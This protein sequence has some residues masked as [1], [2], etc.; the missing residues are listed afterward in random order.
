MEWILLIVG[1]FFIFVL[2]GCKKPTEE[3]VIEVQL[4]VPYEKAQGEDYCLVASSAMIFRYYGENITQKK[5]AKEI[6]N[7]VA[8]TFKLLGYARELGFNAE[9]KRI[10]IR[11]IEDYLREGVPLI[12]T[13]LYS[14]D[15]PESHTRVIIGFDSVKGELTL[16]DSAGESNYKMTYTDFFKLGSEISN[17]IVIRR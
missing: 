8:S 4:F 13:H 11:E 16:H 2:S 12:V 6:I 17:I 3:E 5:I 1:L 9:Y 14:L 10:S 7:G 15:I